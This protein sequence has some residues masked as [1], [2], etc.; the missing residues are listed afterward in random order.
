VTGEPKVEDLLASIRKAIDDDQFNGQAPEQPA[1]RGTM[2]EMRLQTSD[3]APSHVEEPDTEYRPAVRQS[4]RPGFSGILSGKERP[5]RADTFD[6]PVRRPIPNEADYDELMRL[7]QS[8]RQESYQPPESDWS[9]P[10]GGSLMSQQ[11]AQSTQMSFDRLAESLMARAGGDRTIE[12]ITRELLR[13]YL[14][15]W[16]DDN[17]PSLVERLVREEIDRV[18]RRR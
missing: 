7:P 6:Q 2:R 5:Q 11:S 16:L 3:E 9:R 4:T 12:D 10:R 14:R 18:A 15:Q 13:N 1:M 17:L 8:R